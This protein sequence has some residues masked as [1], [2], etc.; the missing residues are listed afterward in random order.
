M[1]GCAARTRTETLAPVVPLFITAMSAFGPLTTSQGTWKLNCSWPLTLSTA[2]NG[3]GKPLIIT[4]SFRNVFGSG[5]EEVILAPMLA[6]RLVPNKVA[7]SPGTTPPPRKLAP[8]TT[9]VTAGIKRGPLPTASDTLGG[10]VCPVELRTIA[11]APPA[12]LLGTVAVIWYR[13]PKPV[14]TPRMAGG[15]SAG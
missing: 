3:T 12:T 15:P 4:A 1:P 9:A 8:F 10:L 5:S 11:A 13:P 14:D 2:N 6:V 7:I